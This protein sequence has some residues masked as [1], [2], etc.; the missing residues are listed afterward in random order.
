[1]STPPLEHPLEEKLGLRERKKLK[2]R[3]SIQ[4]HALRLFRE[5][6]YEATTVEQIAEAAEVS[7]S[8]FF[9]YYPTKEDTV[10]ADEYDPF[11]VASLRAQ[12]PELSPAAAAHNML[13][14]I[15]GGMLTNE[16]QRMLERSRLMLSV[17]ALRA[18]QFDHM[19]ETQDLVVEVF[20]ERL[21]RPPEDLRTRWFAAAVLSV[22][23]TTLTRWVEDGGQ[24]DLLELL[25]EGIDFLVAGCP[26]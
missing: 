9:R 1:M 19:R 15:I 23:Q 18:R 13:H 12:P 7:P 25:D 4:E 22:W 16:R 5:Q 10:L 6:G 21:G 3:R 17:S 24:G 8:T 2:T 20:A 14:E 26:L 11:I